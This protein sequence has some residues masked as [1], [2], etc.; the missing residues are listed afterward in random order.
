MKNQQGNYCDA[1]LLNA[2]AMGSNQTI[3]IVPRQEKANQIGGCMI[4]VIC[5]DISSLDH[6]D[7]TA[8]YEKAS[9]ERR[10]RADRYRCREDSLRCIA[11]DALLRYALGTSDYTVERSPS[12]KP[13][14]QGKENFFYNL[15]HAGSWVVIAFGDTEVG[16]DVERFRS[17]VNMEAIARRFFAPEEQKFVFEEK[18]QQRQRF[19]E[20]WTG[21]ES[22]L[23]YLGTGLKKELT[24]FSVLSLEAGVR[25][26][27]WLLPGGY[28]LSLCSTDGDYLLEL[29][30]AQQLLS[31]D[32]LEE[33]C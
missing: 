15:S 31:R 1:L 8:L 26:H 13:Y 24:S 7:Y 27:H 33:N 28:S 2:C 21:K 22:Y 19:F 18:E 12:G 17:D 25:L 32:R 20:I 10:R 23:K 30:D 6:S 29:L 4:H 11:A 9:G 16:V 3:F 14:I 5:T